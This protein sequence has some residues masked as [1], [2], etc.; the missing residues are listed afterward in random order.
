MVF[1]AARGPTSEMAGKEQSSLSSS[2]STILGTYRSL[3]CLGVPVFR[4]RDLASRPQPQ[5]AAQ[6]VL[7]GPAT[8][9]GVLAADSGGDIGGCSAIASWKDSLVG[10]GAAGGEEPEHSRPFPGPEEFDHAAVE[11]LTAGSGDADRV[12]SMRHEMPVHHVAGGALVPVKVELLQG[13]EQEVGDGLLEGVAQI[14]VDELKATSVD[15]AQVLT[16][17]FGLRR[18]VAAM[19]AESN[20]RRQQLFSPP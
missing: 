4:T 14:G 9:S 10:L 19:R 16:A 8:G 15:A 1:P 5:A 6:H 7:G 20:P 12:D 2:P 17:R 3:T 13:G 18:H 11:F